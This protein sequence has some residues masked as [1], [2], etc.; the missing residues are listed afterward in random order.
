MVVNPASGKGRGASLRDPV[1]AALGAKAEVGH[2]QTTAPGEEASLT[3]K[4][5]ADGYRTIVAVGIG[6]A[7]AG[8]F[9][10]A[11]LSSA[12]Y[13]PDDFQPSLPA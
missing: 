5:L 8:F 11:C 6:I 3:R 7:V 4:A 10:S 12:W 13:W 9:A 1:L 2:A